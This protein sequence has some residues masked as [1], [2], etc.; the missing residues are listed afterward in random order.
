MLAIAREAAI[1]VGGHTHGQLLRRY[2][3][4]VI[5]NVG[6]VGLPVKRRVRWAEYGVIDAADGRV[7]IELRWLPLEMGRVLAAGR[8]SG[9]P[10]LD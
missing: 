1:M 3:E 9:L 4:G 5:A 2:G 10:H 7:S 6:S 8:A